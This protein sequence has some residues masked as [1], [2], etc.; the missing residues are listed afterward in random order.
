[1]FVVFILARASASA[2]GLGGMWSN[3]RSGPFQVELVEHGGVDLRS[4]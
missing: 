3:A 1:M 4:G 2:V